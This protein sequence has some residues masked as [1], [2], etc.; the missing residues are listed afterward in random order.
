[1]RYKS[2][3]L[4]LG[5]SLMLLLVPLWPQSNILPVRSVVRCVF[6]IVVP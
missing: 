4:Q 1:M 2:T 6:S 3:G 5:Q